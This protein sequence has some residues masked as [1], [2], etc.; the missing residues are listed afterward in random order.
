MS[1]KMGIGSVVDLEKFVDGRFAEN[2]CGRSLATV[3]VS[4]DQGPELMS[5]LTPVKGLIE[6]GMRRVVDRDLF[7]GE[8]EEDTLKDKY[9]IFRIASEDYGFEIRHVLEI[10]VIQKITDVP[11]MPEY[12]MGLINLRGQVVP[13]MD[14]RMRF[15]YEQRSYD[16]R[17]CIVVVKT[18]DAPVGVV[19]DTVSAVQDIPEEDLSGPPSISKGKAHRF[20]QAMARM[21]EK[22]AIILDVEKLLYDNDKKRKPENA[23]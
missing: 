2:A 23:A 12:V 9:L 14:I 3:M 6:K 17:T 21:E 18:D 22:V 5:V 11:D 19:V 7:A 8:Q 1:K 13:V 10:I 4:A 16:E 20:I 15:G